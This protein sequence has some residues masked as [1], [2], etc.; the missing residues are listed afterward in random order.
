MAFYGDRNI[1]VYSHFTVSDTTEYQ[2]WLCNNY[3]MLL[4]TV[5]PI[6]KNPYRLHNHTS[7]NKQRTL[8]QPE[9]PWS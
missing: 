3:V 2:D 1:I 6:E 8:Q 9:V 7:S 4:D 5:K